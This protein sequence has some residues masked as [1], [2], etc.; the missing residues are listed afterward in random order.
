MTR[1][2]CTLA[3]EARHFLLDGE[4]RPVAVRQPTPAHPAMVDL[5]GREVGHPSPSCQSDLC[6][7]ICFPNPREPE[8]FLR[9]VDKQGLR[10]LI[11]TGANTLSTREL[12]WGFLWTPSRYSNNHRR[13]QSHLF[14]CYTWFRVKST[15]SYRPPITQ[16]FTLKGHNR[17]PLLNPIGLAICSSWICGLRNLKLL[18]PGLCP[19][20][21]RTR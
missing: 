10:A 7:C 20:A 5:S 3:C 12:C 6:V 1:F 9:G 14:T 17:S 16:W 19:V 21:G 8:G 13:S 11:W 15:Q 4:P 2:S 18:H